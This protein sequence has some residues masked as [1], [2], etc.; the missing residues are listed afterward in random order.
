M[1][2][3]NKIKDQNII[4][5]KF[6]VDAITFKLMEGLNWLKYEVKGPK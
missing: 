4:Q 1:N 6:Y 2:L 5:S 3:K